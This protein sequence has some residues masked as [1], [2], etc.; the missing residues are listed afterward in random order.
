MLTLRAALPIVFVL[1]TSFTP[2]PDRAP[3]IV[4]LLTDDQAADTLSAHGSK[5]IRTPHMDSLVEDGF[6]FRRAYCQGSWHGAVCIPSR[7]MLLSGRRL[8]RVKANLEDMLTLP[9]LLRE[10]GY[11]SFATGKWHNHG[12]TLQRLFDEARSVYLGGMCDHEQVPLRDW[13]GKQMHDRGVGSDFSSTLFADAAIEFL[14]RQ[15]DERPFFLWVAFTAPHDPR[16]PRADWLARTLP[17]AADLPPNFLPQHPFDN[18]DLVVRDEKLAAW[19]RTEEVV[20]AQR[21]EY[22][23]M[24]EHLDGEIGRILAALARRPD[25]ANTVVVLASDHGL[26]M[27]SHGLL[28][29]QSLY[30]HSMKAV[31]VMSGPGLPAAG[32]SDALVHLYDVPT[33]LCALAGVPPLEG[34]D[35]LDLTPLVRGDVG[36]LRSGLFTRYAKVQRAWTETRFKL[37]RY[38]V[39]DTTQLFD[40]AE[41]PYERRDLASDPAFAAE[42]ERLE[43]L[44]RLAQRRA[45]DDLPYTV[46]EPK[47][48]AIDLSGRAR[49]PDHWQPPEVV[50]KYFDGQ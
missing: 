1:S 17:A 13:D 28:G 12:E 35:G 10:N 33:T 48:A 18:G 45:N 2:A 36:A 8:G 40:L 31:L 43:A 4:V 16:Q 11:R 14:D 22:A 41:D 26:A 50:E 3:N 37:I 15:G 42:R 30:E 27:G 47:P 34:A 5:T 7:A 49:K 19:P 9:E 24:I 32:S 29:K 23:A 39:V 44:L 38:P 46:D 20:R 25:A 6:S 21:R